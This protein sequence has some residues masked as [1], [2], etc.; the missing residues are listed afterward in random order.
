MTTIRERREA[1]RRQREIE[2]QP[3]RVARTLNGLSNSALQ[4]LVNL[5]RRGRRPS[6]GMSPEA[7]AEAEIM[8]IEAGQDGPPRRRPRRRAQRLAEPAELRVVSNPQPLQAAFPQGLRPRRVGHEWYR[9]DFVQA[10]AGFRSTNSGRWG[11]YF[12]DLRGNAI[13]QQEYLCGSREDAIR[14]I[15]NVARKLGWTL[16]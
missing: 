2:T 5:I 16:R 15:K 9:I 10:S 8:A 12:R 6:V 7:I 14:R 1:R 11:Y 13:G 3:G 4:P